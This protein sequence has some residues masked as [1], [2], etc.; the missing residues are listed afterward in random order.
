MADHYYESARAGMAY[1]PL[2][3]R[4]AILIATNLYQAIGTPLKRGPCLVWERRVYVTPLRKIWLTFGAL[5]QLITRPKL[6][7]PSVPHSP[8]LHAPLHNLPGAAT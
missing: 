4:P 7:R 6:W 8:H 5:F 1:I 2:T 3:Y